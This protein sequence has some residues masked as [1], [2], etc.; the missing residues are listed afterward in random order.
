MFEGSRNVEDRAEGD[1]FERVTM[2]RVND[3]STTDPF[4]KAVAIVTVRI[5][6]STDLSDAPVIR[7]AQ[8]WAK[9]A[10]ASA[11]PRSP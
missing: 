4:Y 11:H 8:L 6:R 3:P 10:P 7:I 9:R 2:A 5:K 1:D